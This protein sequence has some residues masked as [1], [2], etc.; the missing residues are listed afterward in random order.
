MKLR[1]SMQ[2][3]SQDRYDDRQEKSLAAQSARQAQ[4][5][6][7]RIKRE[8]LAKAA[9]GELD[10]EQ[11]VAILGPD[12]NMDEINA[13]RPSPR[14]RMEKAVGGR[15]ASATKPE[16]VPG[17][18]DILSAGRRE[19]LTDPIE[20]PIPGQV[21]I[22]DPFVEFAPEVRETA[23]VAGTRRRTLESAPTE[24]VTGK[25]ATGAD[26]VQ[27]VTKAALAAP[28]KTSPSAA[29]QG[30]LAGQTETAKIA[31][32]GDALAG[33]RAKE[34][35][36]VQGVEQSPSAVN[37]RISEAGRKRAAELAAELAQTGLTPQ[38]QS[39]ALQLSDDFYNQS[40]DYF[41]VAG[42]FQNI[43]TMAQRIAQARKTGGDSP[44]SH[45]GMVFN[46]MKMQD[47]ASTVREGEQAQAANAGGVSDRVRN[48]Y[49]RLLLGGRLSDEQV[50][51]FANTAKSL[52][53]T[54][55]RNQ[56][57]RV[58]EFSERAVQFRVPPSMVVRDPDPT[59]G[60][61][62]AEK[63]LMGRP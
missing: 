57:G 10:P 43:A 1:Q 44:A 29:E 14:R 23:K 7:L 51:D 61:T 4:A 52:Y 17:D 19:G 48:L 20:W 50:K 60:M 33:Q 21:D 46:F 18:E 59:I 58:K 38:Q 5:E 13:I 15:I 36:A 8:V 3:A 30:A 12:A 42:S 41:A 40:K 27:M 37:A 49:N 56:Q 11:V 35:K 53:E 54:Q 62:D 45:I 22:A 9:T 63:K 39:A 24:K 2:D 6:R 25:D 34:A 28:F 16:D 32:S 47:P 26:F 55:V 31:A